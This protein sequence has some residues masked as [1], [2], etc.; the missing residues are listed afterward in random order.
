[1]VLPDVVT[2]ADSP[3]P[4][5]SARGT[6]YEVR[7]TSSWESSIPRTSFRSRRPAAF[8]LRAHLHPPYFVPGLKR[9]DALLQGFQAKRVQML[10]SLSVPGGTAG[11]KFTLEPPAPGLVGEIA[12]HGEDEPKRLIQRVDAT[13]YPVP[14]IADQTAERRHRLRSPTGLRHGGRL[15]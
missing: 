8:D 4:G 9:A 10:R 1:M 3:A 5:A 11:L 12:D 14:V 6:V 15:S 13:T 2:P 7:S